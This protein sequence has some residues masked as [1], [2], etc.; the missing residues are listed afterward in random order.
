MGALNRR[1]VLSAIALASAVIAAP[2]L[3]AAPS[4]IEAWRI[5]YRA[6]FDRVEARL[7]GGEEA[8][9]PRVIADFNRM[10]ALE[11]LIIGT[12]CA[13]LTDAQAKLRFACDLH[14][15]GN[16]FDGDDAAELMDDIARFLV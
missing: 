2:A 3:A 1:G 7:V 5:E 10:N 15:D 6:V 9:S 13:G 12:P 4:Q 16:I 11:Q 8:E 14:G